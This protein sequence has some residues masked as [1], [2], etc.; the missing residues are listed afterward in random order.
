M[1]NKFSKPQQGLS[2]FKVGDEVKRLGF[3]LPEESFYEVINPDEHLV[4]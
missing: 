4:L 3:S 2:S 1:L